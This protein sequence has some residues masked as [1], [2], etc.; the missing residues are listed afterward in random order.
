[1]T[2]FL[3]KALNSI[4]CRWWGSAD[5]ERTPLNRWAR[6]LRVVRATERS[7]SRHV[8]HMGTLMLP[9]LRPPAG[10]RHYLLCDTTWDLWQQHATTMDCYSRRLRWTAERLERRAYRQMSH[11]F[12]ISSCTRQS[13]VE[14]YGI[15]GNRV[16]VVGTGPGVIQP[17]RGPK[18]YANGKIL[19]T[20]KER[21][22]D[23]GGE[24]V[25][26]GFKQACQL[27]PRLHLT[28]VGR[29]EYRSFIR[30]PQV[31][32]L[33]HIPIDQ[34]Q[35]LFNTHSLF[36]MPAYNEPWG[37]VYLE[38]MICRMPIMGLNRNSIPE[39]TCQ[40]RCGFALASAQPQTLAA[41]LVEAFRYPERLQAMGEAAQ[42]HCLRHFTWE[43]TVSAVLNA[44]DH[45]E[46]K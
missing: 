28:V 3:Q 20:A 24:L 12:S 5:V 16:T 15:D 18:D 23:K 2:G 29:D 1:M 14:H 39:L 9:F 19:F 26:E 38:A 25:L 44:I 17:F 6:S 33:G 13:L 27:N 30:H 42:T 46:S 45:E 4:S 36:L 41:A 11:I 8:L 34:L 32:V 21:F 43:K 35:Q 10:Q 22:R 31:T 7:G 37:L 40:G